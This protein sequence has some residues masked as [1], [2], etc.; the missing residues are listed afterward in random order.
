MNVESHFGLSRPAFEVALEPDMFFPSSDHQEA[1]ARLEFLAR[2]SGTKIGL[3][4][5]EIGCGKSLTRA[6]FAKQSVGIRLV[7]Q[8]TSSHFPFP[9]LMRDVIRQ[10]GGVDAGPSTS[11]YDLVRSF[12]DLAVARR[13][14]VAILFDEAQELDR[15][16]L[17]GLRA[18]TNLADGRLDLTLILVGQPELRDG[19]R[20]LPQL[21]QRASLRYHLPPLPPAETGDYVAFRLRAAGHPTG[22][23]FSTA[24]VESLA[25]ASR[26]VPREINRTARLA[27]AVA[28]RAKSRQ[29]EASHLATVVADLESQRG[30]RRT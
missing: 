24:A 16:A 3:V 11:E 20:A 18:L 5:G 14:P 7:A 13:W 2:E 29:V 21:D 30:T 23:V 22:A 19:M 17:V 6:V 15:E 10:L 28:A 25:T 8:L 9:A 1:L 26:G 4:T 12:H 27:M